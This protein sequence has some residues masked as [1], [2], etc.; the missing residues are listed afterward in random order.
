VKMGSDGDGTG[1][2]T[3][4]A[5]TLDALARAGMGDPASEPALDAALDGLRVAD[6][7]GMLAF[8]L[9]LAAELDLAAGR[10]EQAA[11]R[12][13]QALAAAQAVDRSS[14]T[15]LARAVLAQAAWA[16]GDHAGARAHLAPTAALLTDPL[17]ISARGRRAA[18]RARQAF[19]GEPP[20]V[21]PRPARVTV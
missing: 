17:A 16:T 2:E 11:G 19:D 3:A 7:K 1:S 8:A 9:N 14:Q 10:I 5:A 13:G 4:V 12:A 20:K 21:R 6:A 18:D 15:T